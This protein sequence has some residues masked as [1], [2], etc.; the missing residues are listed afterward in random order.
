[1]LPT[2]GR[3]WQMH[4]GFVKTSLFISDK[5]YIFLFEEIRTVQEIQSD[6]LTNLNAFIRPAAGSEASTRHSKKMSAFDGVNK[7]KL[8][9]DNVGTLV[10]C[11]QCTYIIQ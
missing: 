9:G 6:I 4:W 8:L 1:M 3:V 2:R 5:S 7:N 11:Q 10:S